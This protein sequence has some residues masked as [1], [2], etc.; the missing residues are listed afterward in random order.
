MKKIL[1]AGLLAALSALVLSGCA[2]APA[3]APSPNPKAA[4]I[5]APDPAQQASLMNEF[6]KIDPALG[7]PRHLEDAQQECGP[8]LHGATEAAQLSV[9]RRIFDRSAPGSM[10]NDAARRVVDVIKA[11]GF[12]VKS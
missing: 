9:A 12:C 7:S 5:P 6:K 11:N 8:I 2:G 10:S 3:A 1:S 4:T